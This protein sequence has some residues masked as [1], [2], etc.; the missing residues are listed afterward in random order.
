MCAAAVRTSECMI[1]DECSARQLMSSTPSSRPVN[2]S[3]TG[4]PAHA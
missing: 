2:G 4:A 3:R 1:G